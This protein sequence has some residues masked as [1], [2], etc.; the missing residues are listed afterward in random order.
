MRKARHAAPSQHSALETPLAGADLTG[1]MG[2]RR[3]DGGPHDADSVAAPGTHNDLPDEAE[4]EA[5]TFTV[6]AENQHEN[7][8]P[9]LTAICARSAHRTHRPQG[10]VRQLK[11]D[12]RSILNHKD[13]KASARKTA[14]R[15]RALVSNRRVTELADLASGPAPPDIVIL[16]AIILPFATKALL[17]KS[18]E[19][20]PAAMAE[21]LVWCD[22]HRLV[23]ACRSAIASS[24]Y[25]LTRDAR[26]TPQV[27]CRRPSS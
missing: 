4:L 16:Y 6:R 19:P 23:V 17:A 21:L 24:R 20:L 5:A 25:W 18:H 27:P 14:Q 15:L 13:G 11:D 1:T 26:T 22:P 7:R 10:C 9:P 2:S 8:I 12:L 3:D